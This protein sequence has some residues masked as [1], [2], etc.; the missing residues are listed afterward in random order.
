MAVWRRP[1]AV[2]QRRKWFQIPAEHCKKL[3]DGYRKRDIMSIYKEPPPGMFVVPDPH[4][5]TKVPRLQ[6][7][8]LTGERRPAVKHSTA[9]TSPLYFTAGA[10]SVR[11]A[12]GEGPDQTP[13]ISMHLLQVRL[14]HLMKAASS[15]SCSAVPPDYPIHPPRVKLMTTGNNTVRFNP[16]FYRNGKVCL[17]ILGTWTGPA[18]SPAQSLSSVLISIQSLMTENPYHNEP[19]FEQERHSGDSKNYNEC[20]RHETIRVAVCE[21]LEGKCQCPEAL[22]FFEVATFC[23]DD[24][25]ALSWHSLDELQEVVTGNGLPTILKEFPEMLS[26]CWP[27]CLHSAVLLTPNHLDWV[28]SHASAMTVTKQRES[29]T[30]EQNDL[31]HP[32]LGSQ[33]PHPPLF[34][35]LVAQESDPQFESDS[36]LDSENISKLQDIVNILIVA[37]N[38]TLEM[39]LLNNLQTL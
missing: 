38:Q 32:R 34:D 3:I 22:R 8:A 20:I 18:W 39:N 26:T 31:A 27:F 33:S 9:V 35:T 10:Q 24:C 12:E 11:E 5:M 37:L 28:Q 29:L 6:L 7:P 25:F 16:N 17:S 23:F 1:G 21:M 2:C 15:C 36:D 13:G 4:D 14:I 30:Q 19:G